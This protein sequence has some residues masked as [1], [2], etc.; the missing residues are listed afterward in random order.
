MGMFIFRVDQG[1]LV[2]SQADTFSDRAAS[3][4]AKNFT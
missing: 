2:I 1:D 3:D 4:L